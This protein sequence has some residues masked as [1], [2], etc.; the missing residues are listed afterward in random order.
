MQKALNGN[1]EKVVISE[2]SGSWLEYLEF[3]GKLYWSIDDEKAEWLLPNDESLKPEEQDFLLPS[4]ST[5]RP[6]MK[7]L[8]DKD[9]DVAEK[10]KYDLEEQQR[11]DKKNRQTV[12]QARV[13]ASKKK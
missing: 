12:A 5:L 2:G 6:D 10:V 1:K 8:Q 4:D 7:S 13:A 3:D 11:K 9:F